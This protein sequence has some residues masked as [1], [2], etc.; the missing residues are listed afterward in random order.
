MVK[1]QS[2]EGCEDYAG[3]IPLC[4]ERVLGCPRSHSSKACPASTPSFRPSWFEFKPR[5]PAPSLP[6]SM[7]THKRMLGC[8]HPVL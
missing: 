4:P 7:L 8:S 1:N 5:R 6:L 2:L 3:Q